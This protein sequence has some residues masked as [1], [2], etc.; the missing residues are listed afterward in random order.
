MRQP[1]ILPAAFPFAAGAQPRTGIFQRLV[2]LFSFC[3]FFGNNPL[4]YSQ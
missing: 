4:G 1:G 3:E 2:R